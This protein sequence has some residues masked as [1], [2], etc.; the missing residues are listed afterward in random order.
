MK[1]MLVMI[2]MFFA[3]S[4]KVSAQIDLQKI[5]PMKDGK[6]VYE[7]NADLPSL[8][9]NQIFAN[10]K[11]WALA[12]YVSMKDANQ[13]DDRELGML[14][15]RAY[16]NRPFRSPKFPGLNQEITVDWQYWYTLKM[17]IRDGSARVVVGDLRIGAAGY[18]EKIN[19][20]DVQTTY[21]RGLEKKKYDT[22]KKEYAARAEDSFML[23]HI[24]IELMLRELV[25]R[26]KSGD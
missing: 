13:I 3:T 11:E 22:Y 25:A 9:K 15:Y 2:G 1:Y 5:F 14:A 18:P 8:S 26:L 24:H 19:L 21:T 4:V 16:F 12:H 23:A 7:I 20:E 17:T 6:M 10:A